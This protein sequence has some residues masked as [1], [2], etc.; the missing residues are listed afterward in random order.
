MLLKCIPR[1]IIG[2]QQNKS[3]QDRVR[4]LFDI[5]Y[6]MKYA[7]RFVSSVSVNSYLWIGIYLHL[8]AVPI[9]IVKSMTNSN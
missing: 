8:S 6:L 9:P 7:H 1:K 3:Q 5:L 2:L 4:M